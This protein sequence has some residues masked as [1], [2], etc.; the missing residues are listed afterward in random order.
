MDEFDLNIPRNLNHLMRT[1]FWKEDILVIE[2]I[3]IGL[4]INVEKLFNHLICVMDFDFIVL[5]LF[6]IVIL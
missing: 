4:L 6:I 3:Q 2:I 1:I 5:C